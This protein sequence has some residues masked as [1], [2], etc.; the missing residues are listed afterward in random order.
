MWTLW[1]RKRVVISQTSEKGDKNKNGENQ[2]KKKKK[3]SLFVNIN[4]VKTLTNYLVF[5]SNLMNPIIVIYHILQ[6]III[7]VRRVRHI[8]I[9]M[10]TDH[11]PCWSCWAGCWDSSI[12]FWIEEEPCRWWGGW[13]LSVP[14][15]TWVRAETIA[16]ISCCDLSEYI[17]NMF[18]SI[19]FPSSSELQAPPPRVLLSIATDWYMIYNIYAGPIIN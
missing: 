3:L 5:K 14:P 15:M 1:P 12:W 4:L 10:H 8:Y 6:L 13:L 11:L 17:G 16:D 2:K 18:S 9:Y 7:G 19:S